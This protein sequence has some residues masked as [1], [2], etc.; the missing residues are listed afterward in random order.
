MKKTAT[1]HYVS[2]TGWVTRLF[3]IP[4]LNQSVSE[5]DTLKTSTNQQKQFIG[6]GFQNLGQYKP[7]FT[8]PSSANFTTKPKRIETQEI[9]NSLMDNKPNSKKPRTKKQINSK[10]KTKFS[11][12]LSRLT[13]SSYQAL[14]GQVHTDFTRL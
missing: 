1:E 9:H 7:F 14:W 3:S 4:P 6:V 13:P 5:P 11:S 12:I 2:E 8:S 10:N